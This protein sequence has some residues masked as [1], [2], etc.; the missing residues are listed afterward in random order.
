MEIQDAKIL[1]VTEIT[2]SKVDGYLN[3]ISEYPIVGQQNEGRIFTVVGTIFDASAEGIWETGTLPKD[4]GLPYVYI[5]YVEGSSPKVNTGAHHYL[6][7]L[8]IPGLSLME[9]ISIVVDGNPFGAEPNRGT[10]III[11]P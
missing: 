7:L 8:S 4:P 6:I 3:T 10:R 9:E 2:S 11:T 5:N 1:A